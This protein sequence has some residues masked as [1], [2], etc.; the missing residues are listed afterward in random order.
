MPI[1][2]GSTPAFAYALMRASGVRPSASAFF[3]DITIT[4]RRAVVQTRRVRRRH[5]AFLRE[6]RLQAGKR[7][8]RHAVA[9]EFVGGETQRFALAL[10]NLDG[11]DFI[12][13]TARLLRGFRLVLRQR[14]ERVLLLRA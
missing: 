7:L 14:R 1:T 5:R 6:R 10:R 11:H 13:E 3:A 4:R 9:H 8:G 12:V 2:F